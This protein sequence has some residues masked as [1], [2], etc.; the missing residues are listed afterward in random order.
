MPKK[1]SFAA[2]KQAVIDA[3]QDVKARDILVI[4]VKKLTTVCDTVIIT[5]ADSARQT[6]ALAR[7]VQDK[8]KE[9]GSRLVGTEGEETGDWILVD[10]G[11]IVVHIM[12]PA[13]RA[14]YNLEELWSQGKIETVL[15]PSAPMG[16]PVLTKPPAKKV[17]TKKSIAKKSATTKTAT[18]PKPRIAGSVSRTSAKGKPA[19]R[20]RRRSTSSE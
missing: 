18:A 8:M 15:E 13:T 16:I 6:K 9:I 11:D 2:K 12:Q 4:D 7:S 19:P 17:A 3:L 5:T 1:P 14:Y 20:T 10:I